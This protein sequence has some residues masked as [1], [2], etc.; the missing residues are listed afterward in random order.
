MQLNKHN[1]KLVD[2][3]GIISNQTVNTL[4]HLGVAYS[5]SVYNPTKKSELLE[6]ERGK[7]EMRDIMTRLIGAEI[8]YVRLGYHVR[9][10]PLGY[11]N[12]KVETHHGKRIILVPHPLESKWILQMYELKSQG[13][14]SDREI[15]E[16]VNL[17]GFKSRK[18]YFRHPKNRTKIIGV[19]GGTPLTLK[20]FDRLLRNPIYAGIN[21][22]KWSNNKPVKCQFPGL[23]SIETFN[24]AN[25][26]KVM[27]VEDENGV[28]IVKGKQIAKRLVYTS[29][30]R[31]YPYKRLV[32]C[33]ICK[34]FF[35]G[36]ASRGRLGKYYPA[37]HCNKRG[38]YY[39]IPVKK[40]EETV[41]NYLS[42]VRIKDEHISKYQKIFSEEKDKQVQYSENKSDAIEKRLREID[43]EI[44]LNLEK[45]NVLSSSIALQSVEGKLKLLEEEKTKLIADEVQVKVQSENDSKVTQQSS[46]PLN[47][48]PEYIINDHN[49][50]RRTK[51]FGYLFSESP[52]YQELCDFTAPLY[53]EFEIL[54][55]VCIYLL[56]LSEFILDINC[57]LCLN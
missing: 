34:H 5:W 4:E 45:I 3:Y 32:V 7:D 8:R 20:Y 53:S 15:I 42:R 33:P 2:L 48:I 55:I 49:V 22:E 19:K 51:L 31:L 38:H 30:S 21:C 43:M 50:V 10:A 17:F 44:K 18:C 9:A 35:Y 6:A 46:Q 56:L 24:K 57:Y 29:R 25:Q 1:V 54:K 47:M 40:F 52:T 36:S 39:R 26:G 16:L 28:E 13:N 23:V 41:V 11:Q 14:L 27:I 12:E 37:Y